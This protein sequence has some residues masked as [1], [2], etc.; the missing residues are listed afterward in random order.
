[1]K[2]EIYYPEKTFP[3]LYKDVMLLHVFPDSKTFADAVPISTPDEINNS[4]LHINH[5]DSAQ[6]KEFVLQWFQL[7]KEKTN[8]ITF[9][10]LPIEQHISSLWQHLIKEPDKSVQYSSLIPLYHSYVVPGGRFRE[11]YYWDSYFTMLGLRLSGRTEMI[12]EMIKNF[13]RQLDQFGH[14]PNGNRSYFLSR[15]QPPFFS[16][17]I[18]LLADIDGPEVYNEYLPYLLKEYT[19][20]MNGADEP[21]LQFRR[22]VKVGEGQILNRYFD[23]SDTPRT[24]SFVEDFELGEDDIQRAP[25]F[26]R[27]IKAACESGWDFSSRWLSNETDLRSIRTLDIIPV[28]LNSLLYILERTIARAFHVKDD[29]GKSDEFDRKAN[30]RAELIH[31]YLW[32]EEKGYYADLLFKEKK[33]VVPSLAMMFPLYAGIATPHQAEGTIN[34]ISEHFLKP[35]GWVTTNQY[36]G[37]QWDAPN[38]WAPLQWIT[39]E[40]LKKYGANEIAEDGARRW[41][42][43][44]ENVFNRTGRMMEKYNVEDLS[45]DAGGGEYPVQDGFGWTNGVYLVLTK[46]L[47]PRDAE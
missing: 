45:L 25:A 6:I 42:K 43:L 31:D 14:I 46:E 23:D 8:D 17:M 5:Q 37:Q 11:I 38:G 40:A 39:Y 4:Y 19:F 44:N 22:V 24:E 12:R 9:E 41:L 1:M 13:A 3:E 20:W 35:G 34:Y 7:P 36:T 30:H 33:F 10:Q 16:L 28:D 27:N 26:Y 18:N 2:Y 32:N 29:Q 47:D 21:S 15:S